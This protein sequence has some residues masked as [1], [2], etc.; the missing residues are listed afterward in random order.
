MGLSPVYATLALALVALAALI[1]AAMPELRARRAAPASLEEPWI[2]R[3]RRLMADE[4][5][6]TRLAAV[7]LRALVFTALFACVALA[8][9]P[10]RMAVAVTDTS[11][12]TVPSSSAMRP[13]S[14]VSLDA[15]AM[16]FWEYDLKP[17]AFTVTV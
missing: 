14:R 9:P 7:V 15:R 2:E 17:G 12:V 11:W 8:P 1:E 6:R 16:S 4:P 3:L 10:A 5:R 13:T